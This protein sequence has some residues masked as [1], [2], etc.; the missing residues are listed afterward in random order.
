MKRVSVSGSPREN[1]GKKDAKLLRREG[2]VPCVLYG[3][4][5]QIHFS[6]P[7]VSFKDIVFT[8]VACLIELEIEGS[9]YQAVLQDIQFHPVTDSIIH[10]DFLLISDE[11]PVKLNIPIKVVGNSPGVIK[12]GKLQIKLRRLKVKGLPNDLPD[13]IDINISK[14]NIGDTFKVGQLKLKNLE[15]L[16]PASAVVVLVKSARVLAADTDEEEEGAEAVEGAEG[17]TEEPTAE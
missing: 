5:K 16:D 12:G 1:V 7:E 3:G 13:V 4:E 8:P 11:S 9:T 14:L 2:L 6:T 10:V 17:A 15:F